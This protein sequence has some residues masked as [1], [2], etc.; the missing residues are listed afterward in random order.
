[1]KLIT[2]ALPYVNNEPHLGNIIG[3][4]LRGD[5]YARYYRD[6]GN[7]TLYICGTDEY[8]TATEIKAQD[9]EVSPRELCNKYFEI[10]K[11]S[12]EWFNIN[13][14]YF[15]RTSTNNPKED[16]KW[17]HTE[18]SQDIFMKLYDNNY[19]IEKESERLYCEELNMFCAD[20]YVI[21]ICPYCKYEK[22]KG[23]QCD[24]CGKLLNAIDLINPLYKRDPSKKLIK[25][26]TKHMYLRLDMFED[27]LREYFDNNKDNWSKGAIHTTESWLNRGLIERCITRDLKWGTPLPIL[28]IP[29]YD[30]KVMYNWFDAPIGYMSI[31]KCLTDDWER[32]WKNPEQVELL[33]TFSKDN[34]PFHTIL[35]PATLMG[36]G[37]NYTLASKIASCEYLNYEGNKFSKSENT[38]IFC[39]DVINISEE[40]NINEDYWRYYLLRRCPETDDFS[41]TWNDFINTCN[42]DL[43]KN[44]GNFINRCIDMTKKFC[45]GSLKYHMDLNISKI[46]LQ[47]IEKYHIN[48]DKLSLREAILIPNKIAVI[49]NVYLQDNKPWKL[50]STDKE[51]YKEKIE[52][53][54][55]TSLILSYIITRLLDPFIP[56][57]SSYISDYINISPK[58]DVFND[59]KF[60]ED[61]TISLKDE[62]YILPF[63]IIK[64][65]MIM[66]I[67]QKLKLK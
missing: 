22:A 46:I 30:D 36:T 29:G 35:F 9:E 40:L 38:G 18:I 26:D 53:I 59:I 6:T 56:K 61:M 24:K 23:D 1:M 41:F 12:Y 54:L 17:A 48:F 14:D 15:G 32:W 7:D 43:V 67:L 45:N 51:K 57:T 2:S 66:D 16:I 28:D 37:D 64:K 13:F 20:R 65:G 39:S 47:L 8:G 5:V 63:K 27:K 34:I 62:K 33:Q 55:S 44:I 4:V 3:C 60:S 50:Y 10:H 19:L 21:G 49:G 11:K 58:L 52:E 25:K 42:A 31:T